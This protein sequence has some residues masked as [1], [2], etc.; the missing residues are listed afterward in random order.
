[1]AKPRKGVNR[2][3]PTARLKLWAD[4]VFLQLCAAETWNEVLDQ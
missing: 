3:L 1:M 4:E 2:T